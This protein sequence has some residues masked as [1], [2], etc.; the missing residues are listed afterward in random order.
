MGAAFGQH[1]RRAAA[2][3]G[4]AAGDDCYAP[5]HVEPIAHVTA[6]PLTPMTCPVMYAAASE[7]RNAVMPAMSSP[8]PSRRAGMN[9]LSISSGARWLRAWAARIIGVSMMKGG[10]VFA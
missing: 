10:T 6:P 2:D 9:W 5:G 8:V 7:H 4:A 3:T 1:R